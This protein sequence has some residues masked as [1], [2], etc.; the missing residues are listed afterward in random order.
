MVGR[1]AGTPQMED[2][3]ATDDAPLTLARLWREMTPAQ[4]SAA[5]ESFWLDDESMPQQIEAVT[6]LSRQLHFRPQSVLAMPV[7][8]KVRQLAM[9]TRLPDGVIGR[10]LVVYHLTAQRPMLVAFLDKL[11][12]PHEN[13][14]IPDT[15]GGQ[16]A[17]D[18]VTAAV[19]AL[20]AAFPE[21]D[22][23]LY[24][25]TLAVQDPETWGMLVELVTPV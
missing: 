24:T 10:L 9:Q 19:D 1:G 13:G 2:S 15:M 16:P 3:L 8:R 17:A 21:A 7:D 5:A 22:V 12:I 14:L 23:R 4:K 6:H 25:R 11:G 20:L 18:R